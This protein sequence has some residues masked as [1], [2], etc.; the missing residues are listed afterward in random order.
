M[1]A[2]RPKHQPFSLVSVA[3]AGLVTAVALTL[4][5]NDPRWPLLAVAVVFGWSQIG[6]V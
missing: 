4:S 6:S 3:V 2:P 5:G 1:N